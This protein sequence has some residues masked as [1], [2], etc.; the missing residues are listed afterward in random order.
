MSKCEECKHSARQDDCYCNECKHLERK[1][2]FEPKDRIDD[3]ATRLKHLA[4]IYAWADE[5]GYLKE[6]TPAEF[7]HYVVY[8]SEYETW[9]THSHSTLFEPLQIY[10]TKD[11][12]EETKKAL[13]AGVLKL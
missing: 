11:G 12:A 2:N 7:N 10:M 9:T 1:D 8:D 13:N 6:W 4:T 3:L 5:H